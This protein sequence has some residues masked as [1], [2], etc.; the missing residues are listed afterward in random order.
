MIKSFDLKFPAFATDAYYRDKIGNVSTSNFYSS[1]SKS[2]LTIEPRYPLYGGWNY[3]WYH[4]YNLP[5]SKHLTYS[6]GKYSLKIPTIDSFNA[7]PIEQLD[8]RIIL[9]EGARFLFFKFSLFKVKIPDDYD[10]K[11]K[12]HYSYLDSIGRSMVVINKNNVLTRHWKEVEVIYYL[13]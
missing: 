4:G 12:I 9:P 10:Y 11:V 8:L 5:L 13:F 2:L 3:D 7:I 6:E 1:S